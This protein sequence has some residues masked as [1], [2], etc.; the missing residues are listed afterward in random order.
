MNDKIA[1]AICHLR[2]LSPK[3]MLSSPKSHEIEYVFNRNVW[4][5][6]DCFLKNH[7]WAYEIEAQESPFAI[8]YTYLI[9][10]EF[11]ND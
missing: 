1:Y 8:L 2:I 9:F 4:T 3:S 5:K 10:P 11:L 6:I 7:K